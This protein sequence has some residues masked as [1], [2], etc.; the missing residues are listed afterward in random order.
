MNNISRTFLLLLMI[1]LHSLKG[2]L[3]AHLG[4]MVEV[5]VAL[6]DLFVAMLVAMLVSLVVHLVF[7]IAA[8]GQ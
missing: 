6:G 5:M 1:S 3:G 4:Q 2:T 8:L 7:A